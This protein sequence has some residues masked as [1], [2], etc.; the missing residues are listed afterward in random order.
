V[1]VSTD[2]WYSVFPKLALCYGFIS[3]G[4]LQDAE[5]LIEEILEFNR[6]R[7]AE[8]TGTPAHF[9]KGVVLI[10]NGYVTRG[11]KILE[12]RLQVWQQNGCKLRYAACGYILAKVFAQIAQSKK[13]LMTPLVFRNFNFFIKNALFADRKAAEYFSN[14][15]A[16]AKEIEANGI[17]GQAYLNWG[18]FNQA[19]RK[20]DEARQCFHEAVGYF[21]K[22]RADRYLEQAHDAL[23]SL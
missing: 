21:E 22:C 15:I 5:Q 10:A 20:T 11:M 17:L 14:Y 7:G 19:K 23:N 4:R 8:F 2:P 18:F 1:K 16:A 3:N 9:F 12:E 6:E 13:T